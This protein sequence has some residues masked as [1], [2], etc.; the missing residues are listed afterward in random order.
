MA[1]FQDYPNLRNTDY[2][3]NYL[4]IS[5]SK[6]EK[7]RVYGGGPPYVKIGRAVRYRVEDLDQWVECQ[8]QNSTSQV[9]SGC[10]PAVRSIRSGALR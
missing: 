8:L 5:S 1:Q 10:L 7:L 4:G 3:S 2:S 6:L 9:Q